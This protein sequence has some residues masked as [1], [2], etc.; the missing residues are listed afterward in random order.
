MQ[1]Q[2]IVLRMQSGTPHKILYS[3]VMMGRAVNSEQSRTHLDMLERV[4]VLVGGHHVEV[5]RH[6][7]V[8]VGPVALLVPGPHP[9]LGVAVV[10]TAIVS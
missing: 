3:V 4:V 1:E 2:Q 9:V 5:G 10:D 6:H 8:H 7:G